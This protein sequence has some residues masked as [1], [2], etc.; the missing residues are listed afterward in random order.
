MKPGVGSLIFGIVLFVG[1]IAVTGREAT[2]TGAL[3]SRTL[4]TVDDGGFT[5]ESGG[6]LLCSSNHP[7]RIAHMLRRL[8]G[9]VILPQRPKRSDSIGEHSLNTG[10]C[11][12]HG[13]DNL[14]PASP[15]WS[16]RP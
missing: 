10:G 1:G 3:K 8:S 12:V 7:L 9:P 15:P 6:A 4:S 13:S 5:H 14:K 11:L 16:Q 2:Y